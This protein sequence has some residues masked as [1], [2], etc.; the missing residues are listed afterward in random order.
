MVYNKINASQYRE[1]FDK[2]F[3]NFG[4]KAPIMISYL[5]DEL[6]VTVIHENSNTSYFYEW[7]YTIPI[8][9]FIHNIK[10]DLSYNHYPRISRI[11]TKVEKLT[12]DK[13]AEMIANGVALDDIPSSQEVTR[14]VTYRID[15]ILAMKD[16]FILIDES[17]GEQYCYKM[18][19]SS[20]YFLKNYRKGDYKDTLEA[21]NAF[22]KKSVLLDKLVRVNN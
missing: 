2:K 14:E 17:T 11:E 4:D 18:N 6:G 22:F 13:Q 10:Q 7:D 8:K 1:D 21:G 15:K 20:I 9:S 16:E 5:T 19:G 3:S 12:A